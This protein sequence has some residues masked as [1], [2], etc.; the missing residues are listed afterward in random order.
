MRRPLFRIMATP[1]VMA[2]TTAALPSVNDLIRALQEGW[3][4]RQSDRLRGSEIYDQLEPRG[5]LDGQVAGLLSTKV[6]A[7]RSKSRKFA[8]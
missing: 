4:D 3:R 2:L 5:L 6:A 7:R 1:I 8:L